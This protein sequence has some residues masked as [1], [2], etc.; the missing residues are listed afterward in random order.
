M[1]A[2][3]RSWWPTA[4]SVVV[5][6][7]RL[8]SVTATGAHL[9]GTPT[10]RKASLNGGQLSVATDN[11]LRRPNPATAA[12]LQTIN[13]LTLPLYFRLRFGNRPDNGQLWA[14][15]QNNGVPRP[16]TTPPAFLRANLSFSCFP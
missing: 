14:I 3:I 9:I 6:I 4:C 5:S 15:V 10:T 11:V 13:L 8:Y 7:N 2:A 1:P 16:S 12:T